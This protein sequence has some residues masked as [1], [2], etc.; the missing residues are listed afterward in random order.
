MSGLFTI[1]L[2]AA[3][4]VMI[5]M[6]ASPTAPTHGKLAAIWRHR[7]GGFVGFGLNDATWGLAA[8]NAAT[9][10]YEVVID[11]ED[12]ADTFK[13]R[14]NGGA[15]TEDVEITGAA[16]TL[17]ED[18]TITFAA[19][20]G[21]TLGDSWAIGNL[22]AEACTEASATAQITAAANRIINP[23]SPPTFT[24]SGGETVTD[25]D[26]AAGKATFTGDVTVV[27]CAGNN[28]FIP[29]AALQKMGYLFDWKFSASVPFADISRMGEDWEE[30]LPGQAKFNGS[31]GAYYI[32]AE[33]F[34]AELAAA[35]AGSR[36]Y[37]LLKLFNY[38]PDQDQTGDH[39]AC[40]TKISGIDIDAPKNDVVK[41]PVTFEG[42]G[43]PT[44]I[45]N[46]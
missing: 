13:W 42:E 21:H 28:G 40:W 31:A 18:Q 12:A 6:M 23:N 11:A 19:T 4:A 27:T 25:V 30:S 22:V 1:I 24:D 16:Q 32:G 46:A 7:P 8:T 2:L 33:T 26:F 20:T 45:A 14:K 9:A 36:T 39:W 17:D 5:L 15:W 10:Y 34:F 43:A 35:A 44:F 3:F 41:E 38:D 37:T 29:A